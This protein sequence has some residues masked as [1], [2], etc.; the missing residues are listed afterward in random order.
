MLELINFLDLPT[1][2]QL[3]TR[4][5]RNQKNVSNYFKIKEIDEET[6]KNWLASLQEESIQNIA[7]FI[8]YENQY[9]GVTYFHSIDY[10]KNQGDWGIYLHDENIRGK[11]IGFKALTKCIEYAKE[12][13]KLKILYLD[14][15]ANN[16]AAIKVY[17]KCNSKLI[18]KEEN[19]FL[20][21][22]LEIK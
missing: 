2:L 11:G 10:D 12:R 5:W 8:K 4:H 3:K 13:L 16:I 17:E 21:Y 1:D 22:K 9:V 19:N 6:H 7:F 20:R 14:V 18:A 15:M